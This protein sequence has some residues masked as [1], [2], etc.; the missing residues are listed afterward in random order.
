MGI[1]QGIH[2]TVLLDVQ[3][4]SDEIMRASHVVLEV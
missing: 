3:Q 4:I 1:A 2:H